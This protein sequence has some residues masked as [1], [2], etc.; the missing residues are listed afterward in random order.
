MGYRMF[1]IGEEVTGASS[2]IQ[3]YLR[4]NYLWEQVRVV[5]GAYGGMC[6]F[7]A[8]TGT[9]VCTSYRDPNVKQTIDAYQRAGQALI[10]S[11]QEMDKEELTQSIIGM[12]SDLDSPMSVDQKGYVSFQRYLV[13]E[14]SSRRQLWRDQVL[15]TSENDFNQ[16]GQRLATAFE[17]PEAD[18]VV[19]GS[20]QAL[21]ASGLSLTLRNVFE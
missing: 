21:E 20:K 8:S 2:V 12:V 11:S 15:A 13:R 3:R 17:N 16:F 18:I 7:S 4:N 10:D 6:R 5:G 14:S 9:M 19:V 1:Q